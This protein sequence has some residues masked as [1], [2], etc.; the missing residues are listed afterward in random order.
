MWA[1]EKQ[2]NHRPTTNSEQSVWTHCN[3]LALN[4]YKLGKHKNILYSLFAGVGVEDEGIA[5]CVRIGKEVN[6]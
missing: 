5:L 6:H 1:A 4:M 2:T 3:F